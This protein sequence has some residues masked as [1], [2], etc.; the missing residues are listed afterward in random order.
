MMEIG[1]VRTTDVSSMYLPKKGGAVALESESPKTAT[2][3]KEQYVPSQANQHKTT[4]IHP[5]SNKAIIAKLKAENAR[6]FATLKRMV[7]DLLKRQGKT[8]QDII[9]GKESLVV[10]ETTRMEARAQIEGDG[11]LSP[12]KVSDR[13]VSFAKAISGGDKSKIKELRNAIDEGFRQATD[14]LG[15]VLPEVSHET[16]RLVM[17]KL[18]QWENE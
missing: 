13:I 18:D 4:Y 15:G 3:Q 10:D 14:I 7:E 16:Y 11:P 8:L 17:Q 6:A 5:Q 9:S 2:D 12:E 1:A